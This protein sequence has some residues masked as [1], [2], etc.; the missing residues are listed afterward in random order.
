MLVFDP[1]LR[2]IGPPEGNLADERLQFLQRIRRPLLTQERILALVK[3]RRVASES[4]PEEGTQRLCCLSTRKGHSESLDLPHFDTMLPTLVG[5]P[6]ASPCSYD[7]HAAQL[8]GPIGI[9]EDV[10]LR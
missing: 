3:G 2:R 8:L 9:Q 5:V 6:H 10:A 4:L 7:H 1:R